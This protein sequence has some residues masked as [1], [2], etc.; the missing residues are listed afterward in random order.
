VL[1]CSLRIPAP[2]ALSPLATNTRMAH[3]ANSNVLPKERKPSQPVHLAAEERGAIVKSVLRSID[4]FHLSAQSYDSHRL[5]E[6]KERYHAAVDLGLQNKPLPVVDSGRAAYPSRA[7]LTSCSRWRSSEGSPSSRGMPRNTSSTWS[8]SG[9]CARL[10]GSLRASS[11][12]ARV[13]H[14]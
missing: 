7:F 6:A 8:S 12:R 11:V 4:L 2:S 3:P 13:F 9:F 1:L 14:P 10:L 5:L